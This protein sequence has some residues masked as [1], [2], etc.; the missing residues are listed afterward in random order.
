MKAR[1]STR[2]ERH[3]QNS[4]CQNLPSDTVEQSG[5]L[6]PEIVEV[7]LEYMATESMTDMLELCHVEPYMP[8]AEF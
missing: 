1:G 6:Y 7:G 8:G 4:A 3:A 2:K 5:D